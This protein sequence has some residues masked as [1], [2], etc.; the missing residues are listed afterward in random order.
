MSSRLAGWAVLVVVPLVA[1]LG[2]TESKVLESG[3]LEVSVEVE[4]APAGGGRYDNILLEIAQVRVLP[5]DPDAAAALGND[6]IGLVRAATTLDLA[7]STVLDLSAVPIN[8][9]NYLVTDVRFQ[10]LLLHDE[11]PPAPPATCIENFADVPSG[12]VLGDVLGSAPW[13][14]EFDPPVEIPIVRGAQTALRVRIDGPAVV[15]ALES[16]LECRA[17]SNCVTYGQTPPCFNGFNQ[18]AFEAALQTAV[19]VAQD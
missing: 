18:F 1:A 3:T 7:S 4:P 19:T 16:A 17:T 13:V 12:G 6:P 8:E 11:D 15:A 5:A 9:G 10:S 2:C 14:V